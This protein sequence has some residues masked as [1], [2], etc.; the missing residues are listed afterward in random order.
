VKLPLLIEWIIQSH[1][2]FD[3]GFSGAIH[4]GLMPA[5]TRSLAGPVQRRF[6][7]DHP[8]VRIMVTERVSSDLIEE[9]AAGRIDLGIVPAFNAPDAINVSKIG[10]VVVSAPQNASSRLTNGSAKRIK[11]RTLR[12]SASTRSPC[13]TATP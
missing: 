5:L 6:M 1:G 7:K 3:H 11:P 2:R 13:S 4:L 8:N 10:S 12:S 9:V